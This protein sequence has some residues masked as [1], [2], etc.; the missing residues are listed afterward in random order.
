MKSFGVRAEIIS[1]VSEKIDYLKEKPVRLGVKEIPIP[2]TRALA[3][4]CYLNSKVIFDKIIEIT[5]KEPKKLKEKFNK[6]TLEETDVPYKDF[7]GPF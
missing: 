1:T 4:E 5:K 3:R 6:S 2:S 7:Q